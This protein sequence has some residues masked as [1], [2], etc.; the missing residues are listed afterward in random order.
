MYKVLEYFNQNEVKCKVIE[1][2]NNEPCIAIFG[3][4]NL[5]RVEI[6]KS[7]SDNNLLC[8][9]FE[10]CIRKDEERKRKK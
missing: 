5:T 7:I 4:G 8:M 1:T 10:G 3:Y 6:A 2:R 9:F